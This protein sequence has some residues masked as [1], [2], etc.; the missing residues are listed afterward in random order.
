MIAAKRKG[1]SGHLLGISATAQLRA[2][3]GD[4][5]VKGGGKQMIAVG[6]VDIDAMRDELRRQ[7]PNKL[8]TAV[9]TRSMD[10]ADLTLQV[11][12]CSWLDAGYGLQVQITMA[13]GGSAYLLAENGLMF[14]DATE[15]DLAPFFDRVRIVS[16]PHCGAPAFDPK[17]VMTNRGGSCESCFLSALYEDFQEKWDALFEVAK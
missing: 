5:S 11:S 9:L 3:Y 6:D 12:P 2:V 4:N 1:E 7:G 15:S 13:G 10:G 17:V 14:E 16:C 8:A